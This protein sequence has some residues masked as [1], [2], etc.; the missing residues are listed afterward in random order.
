MRIALAV[1]L[2][3]SLH[4]LSAWLLNQPQAVGPDAPEGKLKSLS[5]APFREGQS[6]L[7]NVFPTVEEI[8]QDLR[9]L[10]E[11]TQS[12][13][14]YAS[15]EAMRPIP[16]LAGQYGLTVTQGAWLGYGKKDNAAEIE[17][18]IDSANANPAVVKR[19]IVGNEVLLRGEMK[20]ETLIDAIR[21]VKRA[22]KQPVSYADVW[23]MYMKY[24][25]LIKEVDFITIHILPY[26]EDE[27]IPV[28]A[29]PAHIERIYR[30]VKREAEAITPG[31]PILIGESGWPAHGRQR[32]LASPSIVNQARF[33][34]QL[35]NTASANGFDYNIVEALNQPWK[36]ELEGV[37][38]ANW[39]LFSADRKQLFPLAGPVQEEPDWI[40]QVLVAVFIVWV[41]T[42]LWRGE[43]EALT[44]PRLVVVIGVLQVFSVIL[45]ESSVDSWDISYGVWQRLKTLAFVSLQVM[46]AGMILQRVIGVLNDRVGAAHHGPKLYAMYLV[47]AA[48]VFHQSF[49]L[50]T[51]GRYLS[52]PSQWLYIPVS[53]LLALGL[54]RWRA[55]SRLSWQAF[56]INRLLGNTAVYRKRDRLVGIALMFIGLA[57]IVGETQ[58]FMVGRDFILAYPDVDERLRLAF[59][60]TIGNGQLRVW[61]TCLVLLALPFLAGGWQDA[62]RTA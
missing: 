11:K 26:W 42:F 16:R 22:V 39:G 32:G 30:Q 62:R 19:V 56:D 38:G 14:T 27:P 61:L 49:G 23:S 60:L 59:S 44:L 28:D 7:E 47:V 3:V 46:L 48:F 29:A 40:A 36:S 57:M 55:E 24:P 8:D 18:L 5:F 25:Q 12:I 45:V 1:L 51:N 33:I 43:L 13:R 9:R 53:G 37:V 6:P 4:V 41:A 20:P 17:A 15:A 31:K 54:V 2:V 35:I 10:S 52:F 50:A 34:R 58:A 21:Q